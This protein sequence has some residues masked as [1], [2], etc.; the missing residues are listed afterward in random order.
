M[1]KGLIATTAIAGALAATGLTTGTHPGTTNATIS[2][3][4]ILVALDYDPA[5]YGQTV[6]ATYPDG[7]VLLRTPGGQLLL[8]TSGVT[9][10]TSDGST[11][12][13]DTPSST[14]GGGLPIDT[15]NG[16]TS[17]ETPQPLPSLPQLM[18]IAVG[19]DDYQL[20]SSGVSDPTSGGEY[21]VTLTFNNG[22][23]TYDATGLLTAAGLGPLAY[24]HIDIT[25]SDI[26]ALPTGSSI[27]ELLLLGGID[28]TYT[29]AASD[30][31]YIGLLGG[32]GF[33]IPL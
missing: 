14:P 25:T 27:D 13:D 4:P 30:A 8:D 28:I 22:P 2:A 19:G 3:D 6:I 7:S 15:G 21:P 18:T 29:D 26:P 5:D 32:P 33:D 24:N 23:G 10:N 17:G 11:P 31:L 9:D 20:L 1:K 12:P 16:S